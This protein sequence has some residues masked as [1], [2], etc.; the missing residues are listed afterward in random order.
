MRNAWISKLLIFSLIALLACI[1]DAMKATLFSTSPIEARFGEIIDPRQNLVFRFPKPLVKPVEIGLWDTSLFLQFQPKISGQFKWSAMDELVFSPD[2]AFSFATEYVATPGKALQ[3][4]LPEVAKQNP[5]RFS[6][7][8]LQL[9]LAE[10]LWH[11]EP[12]GQ[13]WLRFY[14]TL[15]QQILPDELFPALELSLNGKKVLAELESHFPSSQII[16][17]TNALPFVSEKS[18]L[19]LKVEL[20]A[21]KVASNLKKW[22]K[23]SQKFQAKIPSSQS[24]KVYGLD[25]KYAD[26]GSNSIRLRLSQSL[27]DS[28]LLPFV[29]VPGIDGLKA[30]PSENGMEVKG[31]F[32]GNSHLEIS[33][34]A[35]LKGSMGSKL[36]KPYTIGFQVGSPE[37][38]I[39]FASKKAVYLPKTGNR[40]V[41]LRIE[42]VDE[43]SVAVYQVFPNNIIQA[44]KQDFDYFYDDS[45]ENEFGEI[46]SSAADNGTLILSR[47]YKVNRL[48][49]EG[50]NRLLPLDFESIPGQKGIFLVK[51]SDI[52]KRYIGVQ[53]L[54]AITDLGL[55]AKQ[56]QEEIWAKTLSLSANQAQEKVKISIIGKN[57]QP[58]YTG[59]TNAAGE[60]SV[61][62][63]KLAALG[64]RP[65]LL[66][67]ETRNDFSFLYLENN[68]LET[69]RF[70]VDGLPIGPSGWQAV[71]LAPRNVFLPGEKIQTQILLRDKNLAA[72]PE[73]PLMVKVISPMGKEVF[74]EKVM[75]GNFGQAEFTFSLP[76]YL[77]TGSYEMQVFGL[78]KEWLASQVFHNE[79]FEPLPLEISAQTVPEKIPQGKDWK[80]GLQVDNMFGL[81]ASNRPV[82]ASLTW[83][84]PEFRPEGYED[85][86]F[87]LANSP[88]ENELLQ[89]E[90]QTD[91]KGKVSLNLPT[92]Q[93]PSGNGL[94]KVN[95]RIQVF[96]EAN[97]PVCKSLGSQMLTQ[98][99][100]LGFKLPGGRLPF[101][102]LSRFEIVSLDGNGKKVSGRAFVEVGRRTFTTVMELLPGS[103]SGYHYVSKEEYQVLLSQWVD[104]PN[105]KGSFPLLP[106][107]SGTYEIKIKTDP[108]ASRFLSES[109]YVY[110]GDRVKESAE[111]IET[112]GNVEIICE[113]KD[114]KPGDVARIWF[115]CPFAGK[116][117]ICYEQNRILHTSSLETQGKTASIEVPVT[118]EMAPNFYVSAMLTRPLSNPGDKNPLTVA[119]GY[120]NVKVTL[121]EKE[122]KTEIRVPEKTG[123]GK[124]LPVEISLDD[125]EEA[126]IALAMVDEGILKISG[127][128]MANPFVHLHRKRALH[129]KTYSMFGKVFSALLKPNGSPGGD[130]L[131]MKA[132]DMESREMVSTFLV[133]DKPGKKP[134]DGFSVL[135][136]GKTKIYKALL[137][138]PSGFAGKLRVI[139][140]TFSKGKLGYGE[141][142]LTVADEITIK[143]SLPDYLFPGEQF[144]GSVSYFNTSPKSTVFTPQLLLSGLKAKA[145]SWPGSVSLAAGEVIRF[146]FVLEGEENSLVKVHLIAQAGKKEF[147]LARQFQIKPPQWIVRHSSAGELP[148][149]GKICLDKPVFISPNQLNASVELSK[150]PFSVFLP[151]LENLIQYPYGCLEQTISAA[152]PLVYLPSEWLDKRGI[153]QV[154]KPNEKWQKNAFLG[155][156]IRKIESMQQSNGGFSYW[157]GWGSHDYYSVYATHFLLECRQAGFAVEPTVIKKAL[158][159]VEDLSREKY[160]CYFYGW[161]ANAKRIS[162]SLLDPSIPYALY[163]GSLAGKPNRP[164]LEQWKSQTHLLNSFGKY[165]LACAL[166][167]AGDAEG[168]KKIL[169]NKWEQ[170][171]VLG[172]RVQ[173]NS[174]DNFTESEW[175]NSR[176][177][178]EA[179]VLMAMANIW[180]DHILAKSLANRLKNKLMLN[181]DQM[182]TQEMGMAATALGKLM[183]TNATKNAHF[184]ASLGN[185]ILIKDEEGKK[186]LGPWAEPLVLANK[187]KTGNLFY[188]I[189]AHGFSNGNKPEE[190]DAG[191]VLRKTFFNAKGQAIDPG[192][193]KIN[194]LVLVRLSLKSTT[195][196]EVKQIALV[197]V[198][199]SCLRIE[200]K[201]LDQSSDYV[202]PAKGNEPDYLDIRKDRIHFFCSAST[203]EKNFYF[204]ARV[205]AKGNY[206]WGPA[207]AQAMYQPTIFSRSGSRN[208]K[209]VAR[210]EASFSKG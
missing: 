63:Q 176:T 1:N 98:A 138:I 174:Y 68:L 159:F 143:A 16:L 179:F 85:F 102:S 94:V 22:L 210:T 147:K 117:S 53:K 177:Q 136:S 205:V 195:G 24:L 120:G 166:M 204:S 46:E 4:L 44:L 15:N 135:Q 56:S 148:P 142:V 200:N 12:S 122:L 73:I 20:Q 6:T 180:P 167:E 111:D 119:H 170:S 194:D 203:Q 52:E 79:I 99:Y 169:P 140:A 104:L 76:A 7:P 146:P 191:L 106:K 51:I 109:Y 23:S 139:V 133:S 123:S 17:K 67:A 18:E 149:G 132:A 190:K 5:I 65:H 31:N 11:K 50:K 151:A 144:E 55:M 84:N 19:N 42:G 183:K 208:L 38:S 128:K 71:I 30:I 157:P 28:N 35:G 107:T 33:L 43:I 58:L 96:D 95:A 168:F 150:N 13:V 64:T 160:N 186:S 134:S 37:S 141:K 100:L 29:E 126:G 66:I 209:V 21:K 2:K 88:A 48:P 199:P 184:L 175:G 137:D 171:M 172:E 45:Y 121:K 153:S 87:Y 173:T 93:I 61:G 39:R 54:I 108:S 47:N 112:E 125:S 101:K 91:G 187:N 77:A 60:L 129:V 3:N 25:V 188:F 36:E 80:V 8:Q 206:F 207:E 57:N 118:Q 62:L 114:L 202:L 32:L 81:P 70:P 162:Y 158:G 105:G 196:S 74:R 72:L 181:A 164:V 156:A 182:S 92:S 78:N 86:N 201:R 59:E 90:A 165:L 115:V 124:K 82:R 49:L 97:A 152:F 69:S 185:Q 145:I 26:N 9:E 192:N 83:E 10:A 89:T 110:E 14:L 130:G 40:N 41:G 161:S 103:S 116:L 193:L 27:A 198:V 154:G 113:Q 131:Y 189:Q 178:E 34:L 155:D 75:T 163:V 127:F 197:D